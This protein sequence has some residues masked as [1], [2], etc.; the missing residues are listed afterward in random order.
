MF[1]LIVGFAKGR[2]TT[3]AALIIGKVLAGR[4]LTPS[5]APMRAPTVDICAHS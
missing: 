5:P 2:L 1:R 4:A 3:S